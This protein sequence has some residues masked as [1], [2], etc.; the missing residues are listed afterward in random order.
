[1][2]TGMNNAVFWDV[3]LCGCCKNWHFGGTYHLKDK[4]WQARNNASSN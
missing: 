2:N 3:T 1:V 4:N